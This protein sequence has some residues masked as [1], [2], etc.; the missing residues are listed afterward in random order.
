MKAMDRFPSAAPRLIAVFLGI[1]L[2]SLTAAAQEPAKARKLIVGDVLVLGNNRRP[3]QEIMS[4]LKTRVGGE[5]NPEV[6]QEDVRALMATNQFGNVQ[7]RYRMRQDGQVDVI[8]YVVEH[9]NVIE[10]IVFE[11]MKS[12]KKT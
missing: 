12:L 6:I 10:D 11:G 9:P 3:A 7:P 2:C 1:L 5:Y 4:A 8:F